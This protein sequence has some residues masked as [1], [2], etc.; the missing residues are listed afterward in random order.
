M[1]NFDSRSLA[2]DHEETAGSRLKARFMSFL[3]N[4]ANRQMGGQFVTACDRSPEISYNNLRGLI[5]AEHVNGGGRIIA[6][7]R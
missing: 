1:I 3:E 2:E 5:N 4:F 7:K 6:L